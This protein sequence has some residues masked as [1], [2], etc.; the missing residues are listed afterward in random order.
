MSTNAT[1]AATALQA[2]IGEDAKV[3]D[4]FEITQDRVTAF[5]DATLDHQFIHI[6]PERAAATPFG[7]TVA[8]GFLTL[9]LLPHLV[10]KL[11]D[12]STPLEGLLMGVNYGLNKVRFINPV[13]VGS[14]VR[15][16]V[17][18]GAVT[19]KDNAVDQIQNVTIE[20]DGVDKPA[21]VAEWVTRFVFG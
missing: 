3:G 18:V 11:D 6:D 5:A 9:S 8:H 17:E 14:K 2:R 7:G 12:G 13:P 19:Q 1:A 10:T 15:A 21:M 20:I 4:W 16:R